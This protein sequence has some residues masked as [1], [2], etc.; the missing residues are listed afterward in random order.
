MAGAATPHSYSLRPPHSD[1][2]DLRPLR[3]LLLSHYSCPSRSNYPFTR[4]V[5]DPDRRALRSFRDNW[6]VG[7]T[8]E[9][10]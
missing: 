5:D 1:H 10:I 8:M 6:V 3:R 4:M 9:F 2:L 7:A